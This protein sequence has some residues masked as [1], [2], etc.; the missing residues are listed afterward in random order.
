MRYRLATQ[1]LIFLTYFTTTAFA[2]TNVMPSSLAPMLKEVIPAVVNIAVQGEMPA[3]SKARKG[4]KKRN[5]DSEKSRKFRSMG[6][7][8]IIDP[9]NGFIIT[10]AHVLKNAK[11]VTV[12]LHDGR[13]LEAS[14]VGADPATDV[15][16]IRVKAVN[17]PT[18]KLGNSD[19]LRVGDFSV[20]IGN[21]FG[22]NS[23]GENQTATFGIIS[24]LQRT[25]LNIEGMENFIQTDAAINPG[26]S[27]GALLNIQGELI[28]INTAIITPFGGNIGIGFAIPI[29]MV[30]DVMAQIIKFGTVKRGLMGIMVQHITPELA[31]VLHLKKKGGAL[32]T[33]VNPGSPA[34][35]AGLQPGDIIVR[36]N[37]RNLTDAAQVKNIVG[38]L[39]VGSR[40][41]MEVLRNGKKLTIST[42]VTDVEQHEQTLQKQEPLLFGLALKTFSQY[43][44]IH[45]HIKGVLV[46]GALENSPGWRAGLRPG[47]VVVLARVESK[48]FNTV[49]VQDL[50]KIA[51]MAMKQEVDKGE[52]LLRVLRGASARYVVVK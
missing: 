44:P 4:K 39:R 23:T 6:S 10:N 45:G 7:G 46:A 31:K 27:G 30:R 25:N 8:V 34:K 35:Q 41:D 21:P 28:G 15:A 42:K 1:L 13:R 40:V 36:I 11:M 26:N 16:V 49:S 20:A 48:D 14:P 22:L 43:S 19:K 18:L 51:K 29:N 32:I 37:N 9:K 52:L 17:L 47:D 3:T 38:L 2:A 12:T 5:Q 24:A 50:Q 33:Q